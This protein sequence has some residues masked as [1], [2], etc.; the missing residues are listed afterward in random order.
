MKDDK[1]LIEEL[2]IVKS[3]AAWSEKYPRGRTYPMS[4]M[5]MDD[6]LIAI[7]ERAKKLVAA[8]ADYHAQPEDENKVLIAALYDGIKLLKDNPLKQQPLAVSEQIV[9]VSMSVEKELPPPETDCYFTFNKQEGEPNILGAT[10]Y[11]HAGVAGWD[12]EYEN[13][14]D[15]THWLKPVKLSSLKAPVIKVEFRQGI[16]AEDT[17]GYIASVEDLRIVD[18][19]K[20]K[21]EAFAEVLK[22]FSVL[23]AHNS[24]LSSKELTEA[25]KMAAPIKAPVLSD[26]DIEALAEKRYPYVFAEEEHKNLFKWAIDERRACFVEGYKA[27]PRAVNK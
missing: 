22:S 23:L 10:L 13:E 17:E 19:G 8:L 2:D 9:W 16:I 25:L 6:E 24:G 27:N 1:I 18:T 14:P 7:E 5:V 26:E 11:N 21:I 20:T 3:L 15:P 12:K 4:K